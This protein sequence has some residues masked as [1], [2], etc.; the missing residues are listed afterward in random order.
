MKQLFTLLL[1]LLFFNSNA[2]Y[3]AES[4]P[5][6]GMYVDKFAKRLQGGTAYDPNFSILG[7]DENHDGIFEKEDALL[8]YCAENHI[9][10]IELYDLEKIIGGTISVWNENT[11]MNEPL[12]LHLCRFMQKARDQYCITEI[13]AAGSTAHNFDS[14]AA[15]N[16]RYPI[17]EPYQLRMD[18]RNSISFD[19][20]LNM[21]ERTYP[22]NDIRSRKAELLKYC[23]RTTDFNNCN[24]CGARFDNMNTEVEFWFDC[25]NDLADFEDLLFEINAI[26]QMYNANH[27]DHP[28][29]IE[30]YIA[31]LSYCSNYMDVIRFL[32]G[33]NNC[34]PCTN[35]NN[36]HSKTIDRVLYS[37]LT[38]NT[39]FDYGV[40]NLFESAET[41]DSTDYHN[42]LYAEGTSTG[43]SVDYMATWFNIIPWYNIFSAEEAYYDGY[44]NNP[45]ASFWSPESNDVH[46][47]G[48]TWFAATHMVGQL[49]NPLVVQNAG[50]YCDADSVPITFYYVGPEDPGID[51]EFWVTNDLDGSTV[52][53]KTGGMFTG[54]S[55][56]YIPSTSTLTRH[57]AIDFTDTL[58]FPELWLSEGSYTSHV[59]LYYDHHSGCSYS[60]DYPIHVNDH[61][62]LDIIGDSVFCHGQYSFLK[63]PTA[64]SIQ[65]YHDGKPI[66]AGTS[67]F[68]RV[69]EDGDYYA[70]LLSGG[71]CAG[72]TDTVHIHVLPL[73][74]V[75]VN[76]FCNG[77]GTVTLKAN[78]DA[79]NTTSTNI[80]GDGGMLYQWN[81]GAITDQITV[82]AG[83]SRISYRLNYTDPYSGC[84]ARK[85]IAV[86]AVPSNSYT[87]GIITAVAPSSPCSQDGIIGSG[88]VPDPGNTGS[89]LWST[90]ETTRNLYDVGPGVY[91]LV[92]NVWGAACSYYSTI[93]LGSLPVDSPTVTAT[94]TNVSC[95]N[96]HDGAIQLSL[97]GGHAPFKFSWRNIPDDTIH[98]PHAQNL[99]QLYAGN[100]QLVITDSSGCEFRKTF[101]VAST[102]GNITIST[103]TINPVTQCSSDNSGSAT[104]S[105]SGGNNPYLFQWN[106]SA[107]QTTTTA[108][109]LYAG[110]YIVTVTDANGCTASKYVSVPTTVVEITETLLNSSVTELNC[111]TSADGVLIVDICGGTLPYTM[112]GSWTYD[113]LARLENLGPGDYPFMASDANGCAI[114]DTFHILAPTPVTSAAIV[115]H[116]SCIG[117]TNGSILV[118]PSGGTPPY[119]ITWFPSVGNLNGTLIENLTAGVYDICIA[120][121][122]N[123]TTCRTDTV[124]EDPM[125]VAEIANSGFKIYP[126]PFNQSSTL[127][128]K[129]I[130]VNCV[131][132][133]YDFTGRIVTELHPAK[134]ET[135]IERK[136]LEGGVYYFELEGNIGI[137]KGKVVIY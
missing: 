109:N 33:C 102:G 59:N 24:P 77:N 62:K 94:I 17:T 71:S 27:P 70:Y 75:F 98:N 42:I 81:T 96:T 104:V 32:D 119:N 132:R 47:G 120:D 113:S 129:D 134:T 34:A 55:T 121:S 31:L 125:S 105:A 123:C 60:Q 65:W 10:D 28:L 112:N 69:E 89:Y 46:P 49:D 111:D 11:K 73:P 118:T 29:K 135:I 6:R 54:T 9:T 56:E 82:P 107:M 66:H 83:P 35:C 72:Y 90:G 79:A 20:S 61:S 45:G 122:F 19:T 68:L 18:Q 76:A 114:T 52:Y 15:F 58:L 8:N 50:P 99:T 4:D 21:V 86:P 51:Y 41:S 44:R 38:V 5:H 57:R 43:G 124:L 23:L 116:T 48:I 26:K 40:Q 136:N 108:S 101:T 64:F 2:Q 12:E 106:D 25:A 110:S 67:Q 63:C 30:S 84:S 117:C 103:G 87:P 137:R 93:T 36:P 13:G 22:V 115:T 14:V 16:E 1:L 85:D 128:L 80:H 133:M 131:F 95:H 53:P 100:Y 7:V 130:P 74:S 91:T 92:V 126:N 39:N 37:Q 88:L 78:L 97:A 127:Y 3:P